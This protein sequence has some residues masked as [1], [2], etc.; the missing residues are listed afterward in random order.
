MT[1]ATVV[2]ADEV[3]G[4]CRRGTIELR[5]AVKYGFA[6]S[7]NLVQFQSDLIEVGAYGVKHARE[8]TL[9]TK[10]ATPQDGRSRKCSSFL[11]ALLR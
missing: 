6:L 2:G 11:N 8:G 5:Q 10:T 7:W 3:E 4:F 9:K 1:T